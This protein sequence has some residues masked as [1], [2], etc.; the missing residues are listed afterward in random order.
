MN[1]AGAERECSGDSAPVGNASG[2][3]DGRRD[4][5]DYLR[6]EREESERLGGI[7]AEET[8]GVAARLEA[9]RND[10]IDPAVLQPAGLCDS[11]RGCHD[12][13]ARGPDPLE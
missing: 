8:A 11:R 13:R 9:L 12:H 3:N 2:S 1:G 10:H 5:I 4:R 7:G 6:E